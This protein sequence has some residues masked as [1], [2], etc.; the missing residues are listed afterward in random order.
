MSTT[1][2]RARFLEYGFLP[3]DNGVADRLHVPRPDSQ[4][5]LFVGSD[6]GGERAAIAYTIL[7]SC[8]LAGVDPRAYLADALP[9]LTGRIRLVDRPSSCRRAGRR[10]ARPV[11]PLRTPRAPRSP[12]ALPPRH[13]EPAAAATRGP[14]AQARRRNSAV[15]RSDV[16][17][18]RSLRIT[19][20]RRVRRPVAPIVAGIEGCDWSRVPIG[21]ELKWL[22]RTTL[23]WYPE[24]LQEERT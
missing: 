19:F 17:T 21:R 22:R 2:S 24:R 3:L 1:R 12:P 14:R 13:S 7:G 15:L 23:A 5:L 20:K 18:G 11:P 16:H 10:S 9:R 8:R 4:L 6:A